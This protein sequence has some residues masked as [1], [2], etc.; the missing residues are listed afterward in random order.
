MVGNLDAARE[1]WAQSSQSPDIGMNQYR[2]DE[3]FAE[4]YSRGTSDLKQRTPTFLY[5]MCLVHGYGLLEHYL[6]DVI[7]K[8]V[9]SNPRVLLTLQKR[10]DRKI[11]YRVVIDNIDSPK[12]LIDELANRELLSLTY[13]PIEDYLK[14]LR[15]RFGLASLNDNLDARIIQLALLRNCLVHNRSV[16]D[17][18]LATVSGGFY[19]NGQ[20]IRVDRNM[21][22]RCITTFMWFASQVD[23]TALS[24]HF[25]NS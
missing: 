13:G 20:R 14:A 12:A 17:E 6:S 7:R 9:R 11:D 3:S 19:R 21:V 23:Q 15:T 2:V 5:G 8:I 1:I 18:R 16:A 10:E 22:S 4:A 24:V 25:K